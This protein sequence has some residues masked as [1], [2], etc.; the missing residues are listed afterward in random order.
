MTLHVDVIDPEKATA[1]RAQR[2][3]G[4]KFNNIVSNTKTHFKII[5]VP[6]SITY[7]ISNT[8][9]NT[10][11][12]LFSVCLCVLLFIKN[13]N[14]IFEI[15]AEKRHGSNSGLFHVNVKVYVKINKDFQGQQIK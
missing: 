5:L 1:A 14:K 4:W 2:I 3:Y 11:S 8:N 7:L 10:K 9:K 15:R 12:L 6:S 13:T